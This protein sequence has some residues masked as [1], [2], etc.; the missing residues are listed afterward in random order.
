MRR[1]VFALV[2]IAA[3]TSLSATGNL[4]GYKVPDGFRLKIGTMLPSV[5]LQGLD[6]RVHNTQ[7]LRGK[8]TVVSFFTSHCSPCIREI[9]ALN[10]FMAQNPEFQVVAISPDGIESSASIQKK[11][12]LK[13]PIFV[14]AES[15]LDSWGVLAFPS[16]VLLDAKGVIVSAT[17]GNC[18][19]DGDGYATS[20]GI[21]RW[22]KSVLP[23]T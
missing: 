21:S 7:E 10:Q 16:F 20:V 3:V 17:Y 9:P 5:E 1:L 18:L 2:L 6:N 23:K 14:N 4:A 22:V 19:S 15:T 13:W 12:G 8:P 11:H